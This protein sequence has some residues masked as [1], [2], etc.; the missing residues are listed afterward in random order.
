MDK[1]ALTIK[2]GFALPKKE[3][4]LF[5]GDPLEYWNFIKSFENS[6]VSDAASESE[7]HIYLLQYISGTA[8]DTIKCYL[9]MDSFLECR[10]ARE[11][12]EERFAHPFTIVSKYVTKLTQGPPL[13]PWDR[14][15]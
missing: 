10:K 9:V 6:I 11:L 7:K 2:Q 15:R 14:A 5:D 3:L 1:M 13:K 12:L 4:T 8:T